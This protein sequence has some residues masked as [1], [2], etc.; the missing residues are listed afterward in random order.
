MRCVIRSQAISSCA[1]CP[2][3]AVQELLGHSTQAMTE[4][5]AHLTP[6]VRWDAVARLDVQNGDSATKVDRDEPAGEVI[7]LRDFQGQP[8]GNENLGRSKS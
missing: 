8:G 1:A 5:Y 2:F 7:Q 3:K 6:D 4:R